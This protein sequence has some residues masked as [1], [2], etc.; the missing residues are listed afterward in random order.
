M[1]VNSVWSVE[2]AAWSAFA[3]P[4]S[5]MRGIGFAVHL[6]HQDIGRLQIAMNDGF[7]VRVLH[8]FAGLDEQFQPLRDVELVA[9]RNT[10]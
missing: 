1:R 6:D 8:T 7:L 3:S 4:K 5:M 2:R 9:D 10:P